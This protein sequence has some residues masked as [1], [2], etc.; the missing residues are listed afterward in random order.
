MFSEWRENST[1]LFTEILHANGEINW[2]DM[3]VKANTKNTTL[4]SCLRD[5]QV[6]AQDGNWLDNERNLATLIPATEQTKPQYYMNMQQV[7]EKA[8]VRTIR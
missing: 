3:T 4:T 5:Q 2:K 6:G 8:R 7:I 1:L